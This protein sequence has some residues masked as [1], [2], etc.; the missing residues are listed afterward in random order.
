M[1]TILDLLTQTMGG[2]ATRMISQQLGVDEGTASNAVA[3][4]LPVLVGALA[5][6]ASDPRGAASLLGALDRD[7]DGSVLDDVGGFLGRSDAVDAGN[8]ILRHALGGRQA[9]AEQGVGRLAGLDSGQA[10]RV[11]AMLA[12]LV[13]GALG[14][15][16]RQGGLGAEQ[17]GTVLVEERVELERRV[18]AAGGLLGSLL[19]RDGDGQIADDVAKMGA[20]LLGQMF[21]GRGR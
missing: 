10:A 1:A 4:A 7:H 9:A 11:L 2:D 5:K 8:G 16:R 17:L 12:P 13:M 21:G 18:P 3:G 15:A 19:D 14:R 20:G 6:N